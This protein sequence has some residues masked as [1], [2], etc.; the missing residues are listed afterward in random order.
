MVGMA[1]DW[2]RKS[3]KLKGEKNYEFR[4][5]GE[6][7]KIEV[8]RMRRC[9]DGKSEKRK[10]MGEKSKVRGERMADE[11]RWKMDDG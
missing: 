5:S 11:E 4:D 2:R 1:G 6:A 8:G 9:E 3:S 7:L 10:E